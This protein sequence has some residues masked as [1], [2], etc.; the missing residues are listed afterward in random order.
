MIASLKRFRTLLT[1]INVVLRGLASLEKQTFRLNDPLCAEIADQLGALRK[2]LDLDEESLWPFEA[3]DAG[4]SALIEEVAHGSVI[5]EEVASA[6]KYID[7]I[8][9]LLSALSHIVER[10]FPN[11]SDVHDVVVDENS[12]A[13][14]LNRKLLAYEVVNGRTVYGARRCVMWF[15]QQ[16][17]A[18]CVASPAFRARRRI[19]CTTTSRTYR[20]AH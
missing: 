16:R 8:R 11:G 13:K 10:S 5:S 15:I 12:S 9:V 6:T 19:L 2:S 7:A 3:T 14:N 4:I 18:I 20:G 17:D 1:E